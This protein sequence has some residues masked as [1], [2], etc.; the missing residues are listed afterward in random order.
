MNFWM[1]WLEIF[2]PQK[3]LG[4]ILQCLLR[5]QPDDLAAHHGHAVALGFA[6]HGFKDQMQGRLFEIRHVD[7]NL[8]QLALRKVHAHRLHMAES[9]RREAN[10]PGDAAC[11]RNVGRAQVDV[12]RDKELAHAHHGGTRG[13]VQYGFAAIGI[14]RR[15][16]THLFLQSLE[17]TATYRA[18]EGARLSAG[19]A[20]A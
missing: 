14:A 19:R 3:V 1:P 17:L 20:A 12:V 7:G 2:H 8:R 13:G 11:N 18:D 4:R 6:P 15:V 10:G 5:N 9:T 16:G